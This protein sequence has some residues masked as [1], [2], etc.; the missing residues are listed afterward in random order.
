MIKF[1]RRIRQRLLSENKFSRYLVYAIGEIILVVIGILIALQINT[2]NEHKNRSALELKLL[3]S[4]KESLIVDLEDTYENVGIHRRGIQN[5]D[6]A[7][8]ALRGKSEIN[9]DSISAQLA[10]GMLPSRF[11]YSTSAFETV[12]SKGVNIIS[13]DSIRDQII[14]LYDGRYSFFLK[15]ENVVIEHTMYG[16]KNVFPGLFDAAYDYNVSNTEFIGHLNP[17]NIERLKNDEAFMYY[18]KTHRNFLR[19]FVDLHYNQL[20]IQLSNTIA[21]VT[22]EI[23]RLSSQKL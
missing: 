16:I 23:D 20:Q 7:I 6:K 1:F 2:W 15:N 19:V 8:K 22:K 10:A 18:I 3:E 17:V 12:K 4:I 9:I 11:V 13:N 5:L 21:N 14:D